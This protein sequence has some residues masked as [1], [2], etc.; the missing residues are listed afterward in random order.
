LNNTIEVIG[1][2]NNAFLADSLEFM[3]E[4]NRNIENTIKNEEHMLKLHAI[5]C[6]KDPLFHLY[7]LGIDP[8]FINNII[9]DPEKTICSTQSLLLCAREKLKAYLTSFFKGDSLV[10][11]YMILNL[12]SHI[13]GRKEPLALGNFPLNISNIPTKEI[14]TP[15]PINK[16]TYHFHRLIQSLMKNCKVLQLSIPFFEKQNIIPRKDYETNEIEDNTL[17]LPDHTCLILDETKITPGP[18]NE[19]GFKNLSAIKEI[20]LSQST[21]YDFKYQE[22]IFLTDYPSF[23]LSTTKS[24]IKEIIEVK[25]KTKANYK[26]ID[27]LSKE[28]QRDFVVYLSLL[29]D[30]RIKFKISNE[31]IEKIKSDYAEERKKDQSI[32]VNT[33]H[34]W[35]TEARLY[36]LSLGKIELKIEDYLEVRKL[37]SQRIER[38]KS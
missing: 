16:F 3:D 30:P 10:A 17:Q 34:N 5:A 12:I 20:V 13:H 14:L 8:I 25:L 21:K 28:D 27:N 7:Q 38:L 32:S 31:V 33:L 11:D 23:I 24:I 36:S 15:T 19:K 4:G 37:D 2:L 26:V 29:S 35:I 18:L 1:I 9:N 22:I 6:F